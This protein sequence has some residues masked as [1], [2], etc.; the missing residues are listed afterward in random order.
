[1]FDLGAARLVRYFLWR[2]F[3]NLEH[4]RSLD[5][6]VV[7]AGWLPGPFRDKRV[8]Q[9]EVEVEFIESMTRLEGKFSRE[10]LKGLTEVLRW[11]WRKDIRPEK[12]FGPYFGNWKR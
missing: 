1:M 10:H 8:K 3:R 12:P 2:V 5:L 11:S 9:I 6:E 7:V 4:L